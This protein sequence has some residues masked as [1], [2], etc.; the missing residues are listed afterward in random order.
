VPSEDRRDPSQERRQK[1]GHPRDRLNGDIISKLGEKDKDW[2]V[3]P[4]AGFNHLYELLNHGINVSTVAVAMAEEQNLSDEEIALSCSGGLG[5]DLGKL[6]EPYNSIYRADRILEDHERIVMKGHSDASGKIVSRYL[7]RVRPEDRQFIKNVSLLARYTHEPWRL[8]KRRRNRHLLQVGWNLHNADL[9]VAKTEDRYVGHP[10]MSV[11]K[12]VEWLRSIVEVRKV[13]K[14]EFAR[15]I[16]A[17]FQSIDRLWGPEA[18]KM[19]I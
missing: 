12:T 1:E 14:A 5:H 18:F 10:G 7:S 19:E 9:F 6:L 3:K 2:L 11:P 17:S 16:Q 4:R 8:A 13:E 15:E